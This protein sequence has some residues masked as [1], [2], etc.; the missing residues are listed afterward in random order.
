MSLTIP[1]P[2]FSDDE[3]E[4]RPSATEGLSL[5]LAEIRARIT[6]R[7]VAYRPLA[8]NT[9]PCYDR[10]PVDALTPPHGWPCQLP[11][12][13]TGDHLHWHSRTEWPNP[14]PEPTP[15]FSWCDHGD[16]AVSP[17]E[18]ESRAVR[19]LFP[20]KPI[21]LTEP[22]SIASFHLY[23]DDDYG[24]PAGLS[25]DLGDGTDGGVLTLDEA[26]EFAASMETVAAEVRR[27]VAEGRNGRRETGAD[28]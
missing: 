17:Q 22:I 21:N 18:H 1:N 27:L 26:E 24:E 16:D 23:A 12:N 9:P 28:R 10:S 2:T 6:G 7:R 14:Q 5:S 19:L 11:M 20:G 3:P 15:C 25:A 8:R 4:R 13:H